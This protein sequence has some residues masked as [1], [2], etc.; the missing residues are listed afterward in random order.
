MMEEVVKTLRE[1]HRVAEQSYGQMRRL[2][3]EKVKLLQG[4]TAHC[5]AVEKS[6]QVV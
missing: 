5:N 1:K 2:M 3:E 4:A 6:Y